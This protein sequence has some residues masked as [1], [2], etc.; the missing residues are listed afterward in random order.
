MLQIGRFRFAPPWWG[1]LSYLLVVVLLLNLGAWQMRRAVEKERLLD[2]QTNTAQ[3]V[4]T[5]LLLRLEAGESAEAMYDQSVLVLGRYMGGRSF[6]QDSQVQAGQVGYHLW[7]PLVTEAGILLVNR[8]WLGSVQDRS[9]LPSFTTPLE[10]QRLT[11][12]WRPLPEPGIRVGKDDCDRSLWPRVVQYPR[13]AELECLLQA[14]LLNGIL[15]LA[16]DAPGGY[17]RDWTSGIMPP[18]KHYGYAL[19]WF[20]LA[21][22]LTVIFIWVNLHRDG[23]PLTPE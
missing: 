2:A 18:A 1:W 4:P 11:G 20:A 15:L 14:P 12:V 16:P 9:T 8:G 5:N 23:R 19:Q 6:L 21:L 3:S 7:T 17:V 22:A 10:N 13:L